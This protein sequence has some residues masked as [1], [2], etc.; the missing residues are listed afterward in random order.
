MKIPPISKIRSNT[1]NYIINNLKPN[2]NIVEIGTTRIKGNWE[3]D[4]YSTIIFAWLAAHNNCKLTSIDIDPKNAKISYE[5]IEEYEIPTNNINIITGDG[6]EFAKSY[7]NTIDLL[8]LD[9]WD[10]TK[11]YEKESIEKHLLCFNYFYEN[12][13][14]TSETLILIDD[15]HDNINFT[16]K[17]QLLIPHLKTLGFEFIL[18]SYQVLMIL[19]K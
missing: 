11:G 19:K 15:I 17:G 1:F 7:V 3:G 2:S 4:G 8:Y 16:G 9:A 6:L 12:K 5:I 18:N 13:C 14:I 10:Y